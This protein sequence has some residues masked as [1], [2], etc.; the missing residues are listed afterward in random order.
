MV[1]CKKNMIMKIID[2]SLKLLNQIPFKNIHPTKNIPVSMFKHWR[3]QKK[4][5]TRG[6][7]KGI[8]QRKG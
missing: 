7:Q 6:K 8:D 1:F 5:K 2:K 4:K 3:E